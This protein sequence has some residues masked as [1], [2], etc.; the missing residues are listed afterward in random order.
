LRS[1]T[2]LDR[3][4]LGDEHR[5]GRRGGFLVTDINEVGAGRLR[6][7]GR[8]LA[9]VAEIDRTD[10]EALQQLWS[11]GKFHP[12]HLQALRRQ[13][14][15]HRPLGLEQGQQTGRLL[16]ADAQQFRVVFGEDR[17]PDGSN[18]ESGGEAED[19]FQELSFHRKSL[20]GLK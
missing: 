9:D 2:A 17:L 19:G 16:E 5:F 11:G 18:G 14:L 20:M 10:V 8:R 1:A 6:E 7:D 12:F 3:R 15:F 13:A 4:A